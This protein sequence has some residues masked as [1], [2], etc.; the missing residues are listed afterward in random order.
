MSFAVTDWVSYYAYATPD[1][2]AMREMPSG[3]TFTY[4]QMDERVGRCAAMLRGKGIEKGD[5][6]AYLTLNSTDTMELVFA[7]WRI[8]AIAVALNFRLTPPELKF[9]LENSET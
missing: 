3:R 6:V 5:R 9:I 1:K 8:G 7:C 2:I 4:A